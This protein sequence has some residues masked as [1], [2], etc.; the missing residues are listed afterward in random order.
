MIGRGKLGYFVMDVVTKRLKNIK[1][2]KIFIE[3]SKDMYLRKSIWLLLFMKR[4]LHRGYM[5]GRQ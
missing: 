2:I 5:G 3:K 1:N 4:I